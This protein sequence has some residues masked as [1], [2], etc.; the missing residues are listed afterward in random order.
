MKTKIKKYP[1]LISTIVSCVI[2]IAS[3]FILGF[4][5]LRL[6]TSLGG[7]SQ[8]EINVASGASSTEYIAEVKDVLKN[9]NL[10]FDSAS[11]EDK[12]VAIDDEGN[13]T[14]QVVVVRISQN[15]LEDAKESALVNDIAKALEIKTSYISSVEN[16]TSIVTGQ[17][18]L[19][20]GLAIGIVAIALF[21]F[22][23]IRY[24]IFAGLSFIVAFLHNIIVYLAL[25]ILTRLELNIVSLV[26]AFILTIIMSIML[27]HIYERYRTEAKLHISDK[28]SIS[29]RML[30]SSKSAVKS[31]VIV[32]CAAVVIL[33]F[34][35]F[36]PATV[37]KFTAL[38][39]L[40]AIITTIYTTLLIGPAVYVALLEVRDVRHKA[41]MSRNDEINKVIKKKIK[42]SKQKAEKAEEK[43]LAVVEKPVEE[44]VEKTKV[45]E[46]PKTT[47][48]TTSKKSSKSKR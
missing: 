8:F 41:V 14:K 22:A 26:A 37:I 39:I 19:M 27:I 17:K 33:A 23:W 7:G 18:V 42:T 28:L 43:K 44:K 31:F 5:G 45:E 29:E 2:I 25:V 6:G 4:F 21:V 12:Y 9:H 34:M 11:V 36:V 15:N 47:K 48:K 1:L 16:I 32:L 40:V 24:D 30:N 46:K 10:T 3:L 20:L 38:N 35:A 13:Y